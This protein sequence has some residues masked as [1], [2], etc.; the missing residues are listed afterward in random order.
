[1]WSL[2]LSL[3]ELS[4]EEEELE[5]EVTTVWYFLLFAFDFRPPSTTG[6]LLGGGVSDAAS[7]AGGGTKTNEMSETS[8]VPT[9]G[10][11][12]LLHVLLHELVLLHVLPHELV[13]LH[14]LVHELVLLHVLLH[15]LVL[16]H[17]LLHELGLRRSTGDSPYSCR[18]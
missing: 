5:E 12:V 2:E 13:L 1:M 15:E 3:E 4:L 6:F 17:V 16:L 18:T 10:L 14:V 9:Q 7:D 8:T 11:L